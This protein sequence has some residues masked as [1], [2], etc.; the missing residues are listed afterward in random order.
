VRKRVVMEKC[1]EVKKRSRT[2]ESFLYWRMSYL[3]H[4]ARGYVGAANGHRGKGMTAGRWLWLF[5]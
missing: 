3:T 1:K 5:N 2:M 4:A